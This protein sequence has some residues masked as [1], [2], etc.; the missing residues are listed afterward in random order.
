MRLTTF[1]LT[2]ATVFSFSAAQ[3]AATPTLEQIH[4]AVAA[5]VAKTKSSVPI[6]VKVNSLSGCQPSPEVQGETVCLVGMSAG[7]NEGYTVLPLRQENGL[8]A[9]VERRDARFPGPQPA[10]AVALLR[11]WAKAEMA[12]D[13]EAAQ[14]KQMN[15]AATTMD[16]TSID[17]CQVMRKTGLVRCDVVLTVPGQAIKISAKMSYAFENGKWRYVLR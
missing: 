5:G 15:E 6:A 9:G 17:D 8:W 4:A 11:T 2:L 7:M 12:K 14:D 3:A 1:A 16:I 10:E 13:P